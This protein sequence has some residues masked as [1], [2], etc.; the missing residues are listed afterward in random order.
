[1][2]EC[3][4]GPTPAYSYQAAV[5]EVSV[6][7][8]TGALTVDRITSA[9]DCGRALSPPSVEGQIEGS[10]YMGYGEAVAEEQVFRG[11]LH[12]KPSLL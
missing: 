4:V 7:V 5:A 1:M 8:E 2:S 3:G 11:G 12:R 10:A 6:D 9:H